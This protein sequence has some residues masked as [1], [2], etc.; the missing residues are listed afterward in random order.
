MTEPDPAPGPVLNDVAALRA[1]RGLS[2]AALASLAGVSRQTV[3]AIE[4]NSYIPNTSVALRLARALEASVEDLFQLD[5]ETAPSPDIKEVELVPA[6]LSCSA[7]Q[8]VQ[9][10]TVGRRTIAVP[11]PPVPAYLPEAGGVLL[12][13]AKNDATRRSVLLFPGHPIPE[14]LVIAGCDPAM[15]ILAAHA[16]KAEVDVALVSCNS[17]RALELLKTGRIHIAG[18]HLQDNAETASTLPAIR[19][20]FH[21]RDVQVVTFASWRQGFVVAPGNPRKIASAADLAR[22][23]VRIVNREAGAGSRVLLDLELQTAG[24][25]PRAVAG[26]ERFAAGHLAAAWQVMSGLA[27]CCVAT[28]AAAR[29]FGLSFVPIRTERFDF[30]VPKSLAASAQVQRLFD[31]MQRSAFRRELELAGGYDTS[32]TGRLVT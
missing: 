14:R 26:Y 12:D 21:R 4:A 16:R 19:R 13:Q 5:A 28:E 23:A 20:T 2:A 18:T 15:S 9:L 29:S 7:G 3:H 32:G 17:S 25:Q 22:R 24:L 1:R 11:A 30:V 6:G 31:A 8:P 10:C 27:D